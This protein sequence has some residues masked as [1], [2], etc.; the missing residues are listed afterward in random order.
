[1]YF[2]CILGF[3]V[4]AGIAVSLFFFGAGVVG[5]LVARDSWVIGAGALW[6]VSNVESLARAP[7]LPRF[8][9]LESSSD[10]LLVVSI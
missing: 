9:L 7:R 1:M 6:A 3:I 2:K 4:K 8:I 5:G 10:T